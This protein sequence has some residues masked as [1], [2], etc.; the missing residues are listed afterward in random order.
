M[1]QSATIRSAT[2]DDLDA[3]AKFLRPFVER[4]QILHRSEQ[5]LRVL[6]RHGFVATD[7]DATVGFAAVEIY[8]PKL[9]EIQCLCVLDSYRGQGL[10][11]KLV[12]LCV[13]RA[14]EENVCELMAITAK[15]SLFEDCG[16][17]YSLPGQKRALFVQTK[18]R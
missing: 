2:I 18:K 8:S 10:G 7:V 1:P 15:E 4:Q 13:E 6:L 5:E 11:R 9:A 16:F 17:H 12:Q 3:I 14:T